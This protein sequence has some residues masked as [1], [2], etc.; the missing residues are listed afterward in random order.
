MHVL[1]LAAEAALAAELADAWGSA[2]AGS[3]E[4]AVLPPRSST[5]APSGVFVPLTALGLTAAPP[6][7]PET[8]R[9]SALAAAADVVVVHLDVLDGEALHAGPLPLVAEVAVGRAVPVVVLAGR[10]EASRREWSAG[11]ISGVHEVGTDPPRRA[12]AVARAG[13]TWAPSWSGDHR[14]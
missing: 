2:A 10:A 11:G 6:A 8:A 7:A 1:L 5:A 13:R 9:L 12:A 3:V 14:A 4:P